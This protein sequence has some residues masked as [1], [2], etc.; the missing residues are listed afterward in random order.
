MAGEVEGRA[1]DSAAV[2]VE[3][4]EAAVAGR[5]VAVLRV[6]REETAVCAVE[7]AVARAA[8]AHAEESEA[9][10]VE[11]ESKAAKEASEGAT[12]VSAA[13]VW[14]AVLAEAEV[15]PVGPEAMRVAVVMRVVRA[16]VV[17]VAA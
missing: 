6:V 2:R 7:R 3:G 10:Q 1:G 13:A 5:A 11:T 4:T 17:K 14:A 8:V 15:W 16:A 12:A 9:L